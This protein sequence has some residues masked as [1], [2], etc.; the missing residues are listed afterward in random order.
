[1]PT[2]RRALPWGLAA[3]AVAA[4]GIGVWQ[5][6]A[7]RS[8]QADFDKMDACGTG[9][10]DRGGKEC[11]NLLNTLTGQRTRAYVSYGVAGALGVGAAV[12]FIL[13]ASTDTHETAFG[14]GPTALGLSY[15][16]SF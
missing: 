6:L 4:G 5:H 8:T 12:M 10:S 7:W 2:W 14:P 1:L 16:R 3:G 13:N 9:A 15:R 11:Q